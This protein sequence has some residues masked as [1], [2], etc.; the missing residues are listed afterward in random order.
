M[1]NKII[2]FTS[3]LALLALAEVSYSQEDH[4][5]AKDVKERTLRIPACA[6]PIGTVAARSFTCKA[7]ACRGGM[8][9]FGNGSI[10]TQALGDGLSD[11]LL[12]ALV[13]TGCFRVLERAAMQEI[14]EELE[15]MGV[16]PKQTLR[17]ADFIITGAVTALEMQASGIG[18]GGVVVPLPFRGL[19]GVR[20]GKSSAHIGLDMRIVNVRGGEIIAS[21]AVEG[22]SDRWRFGLAG[23]GLFGTTIV[24]GWFDIFKNTPMEEATRDLI[25]K[26]VTLIVEDTRRYAPQD[27]G[28][29]E[30][31]VVYDDKG[32]IVKEQVNLPRV[33]PQQ[34]TQPQGPMQMTRQETGQVS[35]GTVRRMEAPFSH[36]PKVLMKED[37]SKCKVLPAGFKALHGKAECVEMNGKIWLSSI[38]GE[39]AMERA[40]NGF[41]PNANWAIEY[42]VAFGD[43]STAELMDFLGFHL[44]KYKGPLTV[45]AHVFEGMRVNNNLIPMGERKQG[46]SYSSMAGKIMRVSLRKQG[47][48]VDVY[49]DNNR[50][51]TEQLDPVALSKLPS[52]L[53]FVLRGQDINKGMYVLVTDIVVS[54]E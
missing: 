29:G 13:N 18:G 46:V 22:K 25:A 48:S 37:F 2:G 35:V 6:K 8:V 7:A 17:A 11:M 12:T 51:Y 1:G 45:N 20:V 41:K 54:Q 24:G 16:Q 53:I 36:Y 19:G 27:A 26:A 4:E 30:K 40:I 34:A 23:G 9:Y 3:A 32:N 10:T 39:A 14:K 33:Q 44:G 31:V 49:V 5:H 47:N 38:A 28:I 52:K 15:L 42:T 43:Y 21:R 50:V